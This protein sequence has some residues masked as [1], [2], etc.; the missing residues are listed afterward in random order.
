MDDSKKRRNDLDFLKGLS[1]IAVILY[2]VGILPYGF[3]G[4]ECFLVV[5]GFL[6]I[7]K[8]SSQIVEGDFNYFSWLWRRLARIWPVTLCATTTCLIIGYWFL[9]PDSYENIAQSV[10]ASNIFA[11]NILAA[12]TTKNYW[13]TAN[14]FKPLMQMWY[15]GIMAQFFVLFPILLK[16]IVVP[17]GKK[18]SRFFKQWL[19]VIVI[20]IVSLMLYVIPGTAFTQKFYFIQYRLWEFALGGTIGIL[21][22]KSIL[23]GNKLIGIFALLAIV[24]F[25]LMDFKS[26]AE[27]DNV[28]IIGASSMI[29][30]SDIVKVI[31]TI[32][33]AI[34]SA[35]FIISRLSVNWGGWYTTSVECHSVSL[36][37]IS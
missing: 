16:L 4:V 22:S 11:N 3:I 1:I 26:L 37:G 23:K 28:T 24:L 5:S 18:Y 2:H 14:E 20:L 8:L 17:F 19:P 35:L 25:F 30:E 32:A 31:S 36:C 6:I 7:P 9:I 27:I 12:I 13:D 29:K 34:L 10:V 15:L 21:T 33:V